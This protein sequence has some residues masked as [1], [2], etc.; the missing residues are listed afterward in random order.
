MFGSEGNL[1]VDRQI[2]RMINT[3]RS[4]TLKPVCWHE[5][6]LEIEA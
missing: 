5:D 2:L 6:S 3:R 1:G 4:L